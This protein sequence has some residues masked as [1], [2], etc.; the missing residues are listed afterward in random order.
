MILRDTVACFAALAFVAP[1]L[2]AAA[3]C[4]EIEGTPRVYAIGSSTMGTTLGPMLKELL[5]AEGV[6]SNRWGRASS[7]LARPDFHDW[8]K[9]TPGLMERHSP[10]IVVISLGTNDFQAIWHERR[11]IEWDSERWAEI[12]AERVDAMLAAA[13]GADKQRLI[14]WVGP[15]AFEGSRAERLAPVVNGIM[16]DKVAAFAA[17][18]GK[19]VFIDAHARTTGRDGK[20]LARASLNGGAAVGIRGSDNI[21]LTQDAVRWLLAEPILERIRACLPAPEATADGETDDGA[22]DG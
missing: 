22:T 18:G 5:D 12:Y 7:G 16:R 10:D 14:V 2:A 15:I 6:E 17:G 20:P 8:P 11:W 21:H 3:P 9:L 4:P 1:G 13:A 19:A